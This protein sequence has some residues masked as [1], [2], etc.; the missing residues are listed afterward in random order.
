M[1]TVPLQPFKITD[2]RWPKL[3]R[4]TRMLEDAGE[5]RRPDK[6]RPSE[7]RQMAASMQGKIELLLPRSQ[8]RT[9]SRVDREKRERERETEVVP[10]RELSG[11]A[12]VK[13]CP[14]A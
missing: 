3:R 7:A 9:H 8:S 5:S 11:S 10:Q 12:L 13:L 4:P 1:T 14:G 2:P 6:T